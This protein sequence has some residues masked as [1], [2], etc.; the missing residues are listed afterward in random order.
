[1]YKSS[2]VSALDA[3]LKSVRR[4]L[5]ESR[6]TEP[7]KFQCEQPIKCSHIA[8]EDDCKSLNNELS[9]GYRVS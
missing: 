8:C 6:K 5:K 7:L 1:M 2:E 9:L 3:D 4:I